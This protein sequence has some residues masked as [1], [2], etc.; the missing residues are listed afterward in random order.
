MDTVIVT[1]VSSAHSVYDLSVHDDDP[2]PDS[3]S[4]GCLSESLVHSSDLV[5]VFATW[6]MQQEIIPFQRMALLPVKTSP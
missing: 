2:N 3:H 4:R 1:F 6:T 5:G